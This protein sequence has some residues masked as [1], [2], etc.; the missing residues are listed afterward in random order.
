M[1][2][3]PEL[4]VLHTLR[5]GGVM[6][7]ADIGGR[8]QR[9][10][11]EV[12]AVLGL[13]ADRDLVSHHSGSLTGWSLTVSGRARGE[14]LA[15]C[16]IDALGARALLEEAYGR[17]LEVNPQVLA[18]C[19]DWQVVAGTDP[20][21]L[22]DHADPEYDHEVLER[23]GRLHALAVDMLGEVTAVLGRYGHYAP[24]LGRA[25]AGARAGGVEWVTRPVIDS[26][27]TVWF[28]LHEDLLASLGRRRS[29][30]R[31]HDTTEER[32]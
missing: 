24:R 22:N 12:G 4:L 18:V 3:V 5:V 13:L 7:A 17:F 32:R 8:L 26:Y 19:T 15:A 31:S 23:L 14:H 28:E 21:V 20:M 10:A 16:Q 9:P 11:H 25:L 2:D 6:E 27:H 1:P 30:E 29:D